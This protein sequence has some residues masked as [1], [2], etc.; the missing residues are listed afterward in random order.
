MSNANSNVSYP[1]IKKWNGSP[2]VNSLNKRSEA[3][4][5]EV[6]NLRNKTY[7]S[8]SWLVNT[9][10]FVAVFQFSVSIIKNGFTGYSTGSQISHAIGFMEGLNFIMMQFSVLC[11]STIL[12]MIAFKYLSKKTV[13]ISAGLVGIPAL[14]VSLWANIVWMYAVQEGVDGSPVVALFKEIGGRSYSETQW[15]VNG[16]ISISTEISLF[17]IPFILTFLSTPKRERMLSKRIVK[18]SELTEKNKMDIGRAIAEADD[19]EDQIQQKAF[20]AKQE[21]RRLANLKMA[22]STL[23]NER[24]IIVGYLKYNAQSGFVK[25]IWWRV[26]YFL[27]G[28]HNVPSGYVEQVLESS[29]KKA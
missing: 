28:K 16:F 12:S 24:L 22:N 17:C 14:M 26:M 23:I 11:A 5:I 19:T 20:S 29:V 21:R 15:L 8:P 9:L 7:R 10:F 27:L 4:L 18:A 2:V 3:K 6:E 1:K 13:L 25:S